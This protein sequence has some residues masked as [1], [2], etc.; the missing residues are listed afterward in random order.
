VHKIATLA[1]G[2]PSF[3][4]QVSGQQ[5]DNAS[6]TQLRA[7][8]PV[9]RPNA[10]S[11]GITKAIDGTAISNRIRTT[12]QPLPRISPEIFGAQ[13]QLRGRQRLTLRRRELRIFSFVTWT[14]P[15]IA[16]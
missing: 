11:D 15:G 1:R 5:V 3:C 2:M 9:A 16:I 10:A 14:D 6:S 12:L 7:P 4:N 8:L 13:N